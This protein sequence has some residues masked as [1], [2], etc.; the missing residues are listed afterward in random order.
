MKK[1][2][3]TESITNIEN[4]LV[5]SESW[6]S[7][8]IKQKRLSKYGTK[9]L[10]EQS[11]IFSPSIT[12]ALDINHLCQQQVVLLKINLVLYEGLKLGFDL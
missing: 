2:E 4:L 10:L 12:I 7:L 6:Y 9:D 1:Q 11:K 3:C 5:K 8:W